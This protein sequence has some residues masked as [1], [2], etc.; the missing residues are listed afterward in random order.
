MIRTMTAREHCDLQ[1]GVYKCAVSSLCLLSGL[2]LA[3]SACL[4]RQQRAQQASKRRAK[5]EA[6]SA[7]AVVQSI[8]AQ[9]PCLDGGDCTWPLPSQLWPL[10]MKHLT[11]ALSLFAALES[12]AWPASHRSRMADLDNRLWGLTEVVRVMANFSLACKHFRCGV[13]RCTSA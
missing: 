8:G 2:Q 1:L 13:T 4:C 12:Y 7:A 11:G 6:A 10:I 3:Q 9:Q 5:T